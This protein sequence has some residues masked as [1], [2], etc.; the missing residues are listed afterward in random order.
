MKCTVYRLG[1]PVVQSDTDIQTAQQCSWHRQLYCSNVNVEWILMFWKLQARQ[2]VMLLWLNFVY[3]FPY[4][5]V[6][7]FIHDI[8]FSDVCWWNYAP[9]ICNFLLDTPS[10]FCS[11][12]WLFPLIVEL[13]WVTIS[14]VIHSGITQLFIPLYLQIS[15]RLLED[16]KSQVS[17]NNCK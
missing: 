16:Y 10:N 5:K 6:T 3:H 11:D 15:K 2:L 1:P 4:K 8:Q 12:S 9:Q 14:T 17:K 13:T 7:L